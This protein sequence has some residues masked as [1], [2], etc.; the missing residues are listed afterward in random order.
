[1]KNKINNFLFIA[2][3]LCLF[4][5]TLSSFLHLYEKRTNITNKIL[6]NKNLFKANNTYKKTYENDEYWANEIL[7][8][9]Y[10]LHFRHTER[11][12]WIDVK[13][14]DAIESD[15]HDNGLNESR[16]AEN[17]Y[18]AGAVCLNERGKIQAKAISEHIKN[19]RLPIGKIYSSTSCRARQTANLAFGGYDSLH[20]ILVHTG[21]YKENKNQRLNNIKNFY[22]K[23]PLQKGKNTIVSSHNSVIECEMFVIECREVSLGEGGFF[24]ISK[25]DKKLYLE[26]EFH[27]FVHFSK[28]FYE[29]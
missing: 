14:Y 16:Y 20:R 3:I 21:T 29:R 15:L 8:G 28:N 23:L 17:D 13:M 1:M 27:N 25:K 18:F 26:Y 11:D 10:I 19:I 5:I 24:I 22:L 12:K 6:D 4:I 7:N 9:G 2:L